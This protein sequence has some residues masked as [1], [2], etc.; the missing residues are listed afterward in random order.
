MILLKPLLS[1]KTMRLAQEGQFTFSVIKSATKSA[2]ARAVESQ[3]KVN[4]VKVTT[5]KNKAVVT[6]KPGQTIEFFQ[7]PKKSK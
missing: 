6:L 4:A 7:L 1:E 3:F 5:S 2:I